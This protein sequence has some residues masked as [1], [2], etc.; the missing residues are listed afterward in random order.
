MGV[1]KNFFEKIKYRHSLKELERFT[2]QEKLKFQG[3]I[4]SHLRLTCLKR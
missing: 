3:E 1:I 4:L 2:K